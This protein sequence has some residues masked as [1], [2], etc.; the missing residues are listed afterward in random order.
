ML[1]AR[2]K[3]KKHSGPVCS[4]SLQFEKG[5]PKGQ[6]ASQRRLPAFMLRALPPTY[7]SPFYVATS[8]IPS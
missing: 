8:Y 3:V 2:N 5:P 7:L 4:I 1:S 6:E